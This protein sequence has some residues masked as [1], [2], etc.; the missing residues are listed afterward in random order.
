M[1]GVKTPLS[2]HDGRHKNEQC[3]VHFKSKSTSYTFIHV[4]FTNKIL[5]IIS[6]KD[7][8]EDACFEGEKGALTIELEKPT[9]LAS[10]NFQFRK[11]DF[12]SFYPKDIILY[13]C[14]PMS[15]ALIALKQY[16]FQGSDNQEDR[17]KPLMTIRIKQHSKYQHFTFKVKSNSSMR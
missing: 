4:Y 9:V 16:I 13:V 5:D 14:I 8:A 11:E 6:I 10:I 1:H 17:M 3:F 15:V 7:D 12:D 2:E